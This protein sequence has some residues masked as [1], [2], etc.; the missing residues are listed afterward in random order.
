MLSTEWSGVDLAAWLGTNQAMAASSMPAYG[1]VV[2]C[3]PR[4]PLCD[5]VYSSTLELAPL[6]FPFR[7]LDSCLDSCNTSIIVSPTVDA[8][9]AR[10]RRP[11]LLPASSS[12]STLFSSCVARP[13][14]RPRS[15][16][17]PCRYPYLARC[18]VA[19][20][21]V[22]PDMQLPSSPSSSSSSSPSPRTDPRLLACFF[23]FLLMCALAL[24]LRD[25][26]DADTSRAAISN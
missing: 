21:P 12:P 3:G 20:L 22:H 15:L 4:L 23:L 8:V 26:A 2:L 7:H 25:L 5:D 6:C 19:S 11:P 13:C 9:N 1:S 18:S 14:P 24:P 10:P 17:F 16:P